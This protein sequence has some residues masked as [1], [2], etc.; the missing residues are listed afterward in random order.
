MV[1]G[2]YEE[3]G[4]YYASIVVCFHKKM[5]LTVNKRVDWDPFS[6]RAV[7]PPFSTILAGYSHASTVPQSPDFAVCQGGIESMLW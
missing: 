5:H 7:T 3:Q 6:A 4:L 2:K 1:S